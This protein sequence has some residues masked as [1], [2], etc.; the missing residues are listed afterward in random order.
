VPS[1]D[2]VEI[3]E[4]VSGLVFR[5]YFDRP[6]LPRR[7]HVEA[8]RGI[9]PETAIRAWLDPAT[10]VTYLSAKRAFESTTDRYTVGWLWLEPGRRVLIFTCVEVPRT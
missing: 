5:F 8:R 1:R 7:L 10:V 4:F 9:S 6:P 3:P 2:Y